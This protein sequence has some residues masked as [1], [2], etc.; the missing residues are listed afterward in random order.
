MRIVRR[1]L[2]AALTRFFTT[3]PAGRYAGLDTAVDCVDWLGAFRFVSPACGAAVPHA[4]LSTHLDQLAAQ[5]SVDQ[6]QNSLAAGLSDPRF[7]KP[8]SG[9]YWQIDLRGKV[10]AKLRA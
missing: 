1:W 4:E 8:Y 5:L 7:S 3:T 2:C 9:H 6:G 10:V